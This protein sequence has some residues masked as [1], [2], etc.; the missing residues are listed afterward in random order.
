MDQEYDSL[1]NNKTWEF[2]GLPPNCIA[3]SYKWI[4]SKKYNM[5]VSIA[6]YKA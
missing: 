3:I 4:L 2:V 1:V 6:Q 5:S